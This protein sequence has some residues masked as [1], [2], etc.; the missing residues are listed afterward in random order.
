MGCVWCAPSSTGEEN[1]TVN[2]AAI[3]TR[4]MTTPVPVERSR[5]NHK[6]RNLT[7]LPAG[8][9]VPIAVVPLLREDAASMSVSLA[10]EMQETVE[11]LLNSVNVNVQCWLFP[12][13]ASTR[14]RSMDDINLSYAGEPRGTDPV[15]PWFELAAAGAYGTNAI[16]DRLG[17]HAKATDM[18]NMAYVEAYNAIWNHRATEVSPNIT[19]RARLDKTLA[20]AFWPKNMFSHIVPDFDQAVMEGEVA[21]NVTNQMLPLKAPDGSAG[22]NVKFAGGSTRGLVINAGDNIVRGAGA[23]FGSTQTITEFTNVFAELQD[24]GITVSLANIELARKTQA[25]ADI[26]KQYNGLSEE[27]LIDLLMDGISVPEQMWKQPILLKAAQTQFGMA[28]RYASNGEALTQS[29]VNGAAAVE[30][31]VATPKVPCGGVIMI[32]AEIAPEQLFERRLDP[33]LHA[34]GVADLP[35]YTRDFLD[36]EKVD[37]VPNRYIDIDHDTPTDVYGYAPLNYLW[38]DAGPGIGGR[39]IRPTVDASFDEDRQVIWA[40]ETQNPTLSEDAY[41]VPAD[42]HLKPFWTSTIDPFDCI[43][44]GETVITGNTVFGPR[45][46]EAQAASDYDKVMEKVDVVRIE[47]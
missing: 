12:N 17:K 8:K 25:W 45:L 43:T 44:I 7:S 13:L 14:F 2:D 6:I 41:L 19:H 15:V 21:L 24:N 9:C 18:V 23:N 42:I 34:Q 33:Y 38:N 3:Q 10:F 20:Q 28:K 4:K 27:M 35:A 16:H 5:R 1:M 32:T 37:V 36:P 30:F 26:R 29:V 47:K 11:I 22:I 46:I 39:F 40:V 31:R